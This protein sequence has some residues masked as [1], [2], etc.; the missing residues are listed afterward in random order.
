[1]VACVPQTGRPMGMACFVG[2]VV[3]VLVVLGR[4][5]SQSV[6]LLYTGCIDV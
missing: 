2:E 1:M 4:S 3:L 6:Y 5:V